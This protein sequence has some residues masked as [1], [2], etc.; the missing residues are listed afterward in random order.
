MRSIDVRLIVSIIELKQDLLSIFWEEVIFFSKYFEK[1][2]RGLV[3]SKVKSSF[4]FSDLLVR[5]S[6]VLVVLKLC[7]HVMEHAC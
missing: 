7:V 6:S 2:L 1:Q 5:V 4:Q 3:F